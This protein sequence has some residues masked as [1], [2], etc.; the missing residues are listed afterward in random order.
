MLP[1]ITSPAAVESE[2]R[3]RIAGEV[4]EA[5][6]ASTGC[7]ERS[8]HCTGRR[9]PTGAGIPPAAAVLRLCSSGASLLLGVALPVGGGFV[10]P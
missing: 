5:V 4:N 6:V 3:N 7:G 10:A 8:M 1:A 9:W 2:R